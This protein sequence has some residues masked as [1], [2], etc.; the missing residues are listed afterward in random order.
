[1]ELRRLRPDLPLLCDPSHI[2]GTQT[3]VPEVAH[4]A[5]ALGFDG[6]MLEVHPQPAQALSD[7]RQQLNFAQTTALL[8]QLVRPHTHLP[9]SEALLH[10]A[11]LRAQM[12]EVDHQLLHYLAQRQQLAAQVGELK[13]Q[14]GLMPYQP[15]RWEEVYATRQLAA[16]ALCLSP[17]FVQQLWRLLHVEALEMQ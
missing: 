2:A 1:L 3:L 8:A 15:Q 12:D 10:L 16:Q 5:M 11:E 13:A 17:Q 4:K 9:E 6:L 14:H 7:A